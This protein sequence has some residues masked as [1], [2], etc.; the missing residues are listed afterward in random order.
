MPGTVINRHGSRYTYDRIPDPHES[1][2]A[3]DTPLSIPPD[4]PFVDRPVSF[5]DGERNPILPG[6]LPTHVLNAEVRTGIDREIAFLIRLYLQ[7]IADVESSIG[8]S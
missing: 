3:P 7:K 6:R 5:V 4:A 2:A 8:T 1:C